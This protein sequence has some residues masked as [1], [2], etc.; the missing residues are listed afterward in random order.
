MST[1]RHVFKNKK[2]LIEESV[3]ASD[4]V[5]DVGFWGQGVT[6]TDP[7]WPHKLLK[8]TGA[9]VYGLDMV[10]DRELFPDQTRYQE[11]SAEDFS[12]PN[13]SFDVIFAGDLIEHLTNPGLFLAR[14]KEHLKPGG[15]IV[16][17]TPNTFN[18]FNLAGKLTNDEPAVN[19][20]H[21][22]Y[23]NGKTLR[24]LLRK[25]GFS[26]EKY[27]YIY[28]LEYDYKESLRKKFLNG[29]YRV[30]GWFTPK[31]M[32]TLVIIAVRS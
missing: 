19:A 1:S 14:C 29:L 21:T 17:T 25:C 6:H 28:S 27:Q 24:T 12:F 2:D 18:L 15:R 23:F 7:Q 3:Q 9:S 26:I 4:T 22:M 31:F 8:N 5:L 11:A 16:L 30:V 20:D 13:V 32:E 10:I